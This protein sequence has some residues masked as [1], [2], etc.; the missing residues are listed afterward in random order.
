MK[1]VVVIIFIQPLS[2]CFYVQV[3]QYYKIYKFLNRFQNTLPYWQIWPMGISPIVSILSTKICGYLKVTGHVYG[4]LNQL[5][6]PTKQ[7]I[8]HSPPSC[9]LHAQPNLPVN[10]DPNLTPAGRCALKLHYPA[11]P[12][13]YNCLRT[14]LTIKNLN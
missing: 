6:H 11:T 14:L 10:P 13:L 12:L 9:S 4:K 8:T 5:D 2:L 3:C 7:P 1:N